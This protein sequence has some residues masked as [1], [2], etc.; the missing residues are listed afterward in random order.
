MEFDNHLMRRVVFLRWYFGFS[1]NCNVC[2]LNAIFVSS[3]RRYLVTKG[4]SEVLLASPTQKMEEEPMH[5]LFRPAYW[6]R[7]YDFAYWQQ[8]KRHRSDGPAVVTLRLPS[9]PPDEYST[10]SFVELPGREQVNVK[11]TYYKEGKQVLPF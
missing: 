7:P 9:H 8:G 3:P 10:F 4:L 1:L 5:C 11:Q 2:V 6:R